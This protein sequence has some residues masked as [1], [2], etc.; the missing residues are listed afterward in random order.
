MQR[1][2]ETAIGVIG[3]ADS[4]LSQQKETVL[5]P[6]VVPRATRIVRIGQNEMSDA[7]SSVFSL[8]DLNHLTEVAS[9]L[10]HPSSLVGSKLCTN[11][12]SVRGSLSSRAQSPGSRGSWQLRAI[13]PQLSGEDS[14][15]ESPVRA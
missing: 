8:I 2:E 12:D 7:V 11:Q 10:T 9:L 6:R 3:N 13:L 15:I 5:R 1:N 14:Q 4:V